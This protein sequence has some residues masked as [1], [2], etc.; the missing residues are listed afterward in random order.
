[1][2]HFNELRPRIIAEVTRRVA[3][4]RKQAAER[5]HDDSLA[6]VLNDL[7]IHE[8]R[9]LRKI[10]PPDTPEDK[11]RVDEV[12][13]AL[14]RGAS[15]DELLRLTAQQVRAYAEDIAGTFSMASYRIA[16]KVVTPVLSLML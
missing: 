3:E 9:R 13:R 12:A 5:N 6:Y 2:F 4:S 8:Q 7:V 16:T 14:Q 1:M 15:D 10:A 11:R